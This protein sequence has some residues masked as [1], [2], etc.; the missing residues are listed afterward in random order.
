MIDKDTRSPDGGDS[1]WTEDN[2]FDGGSVEETQHHDL[3]VGRRR[4]RRNRSAR[5]MTYN[6]RQCRWG[7]IPNSHIVT[8]LQQTQHHGRSQ[9]TEPAKSNFHNCFKLVQ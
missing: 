7:P 5:S 2:L 3:R 4:G 8:G 9:S 6:G 1:L